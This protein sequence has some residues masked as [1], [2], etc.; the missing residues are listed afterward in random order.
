TRRS[1]D[2]DLLLLVGQLAHDT[3]LAGYDTQRVLRKASKKRGWSYAGSQGSQTG[4][5]LR[6]CSRASVIVFM[7]TRSASGIRATQPQ[8][9]RWK[10]REPRCAQYGSPCSTI[11]VPTVTGWSL[12][13]GVVTS[14][15]DGSVVEAS[16]RGD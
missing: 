15:A 4:Q 5:V 6:P 1:S 16:V 13:L 7:Y 10:S 8:S 9:R 12:G 11:S 3:S 2:L 14:L